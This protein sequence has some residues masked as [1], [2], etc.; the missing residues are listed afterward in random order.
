[1][2][3]LTVASLEFIFAWGIDWARTGQP[4]QWLVELSA[5]EVSHK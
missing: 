5:Q 3:I 1:M 2:A 4:P